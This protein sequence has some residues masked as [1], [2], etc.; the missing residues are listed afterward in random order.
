MAARIAIFA[1]G[2]RGDVEPF[3][4]LALMLKSRGHEVVL[5]APDDFGGMIGRYGVDF[6]SMGVAM[7]DTL[8]SPD[9][10]GA[11]RGNPFSIARLWRDAGIA[12]V[13]GGIDAMEAVGF[14]ADVLIHHPKVMGVSDLAEA[15]GAMVVCASPV[16][17][18]ETSEFPLISIAKDLGPLNKMSWRPLRSARAFYR[19][20]LT[21]WRDNL[22]LKGAW[23]PRPGTDPVF[24]ADMTL[25]AVSPTVMP[26][27]RD[28]RATTHVTGYWRIPNDTEWIPDRSLSD[29]LAYGP[30]PLYI[31]FGSM[32]VRD[33][34][35]DMISGALVYASMRAVVSAGW[36]RLTVDS[37]HVLNIGS[38]PHDWLFRHV[39]GVVHHGGAGTTAAGLRAGLPTLVCPAGVDQPFWGRRVRRLG[40]GPEPVPLKTATRD[41]LADGIRATLRTP[42]FAEAAEAVGHRIRG[43]DGLTRAADLIEATLAARR[44]PR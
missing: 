19:K 31:G 20:S 38:V 17:I 42:R 8:D 29:F 18:E 15:T 28:W 24:G 13:E 4:A 1:Q 41:T 6:T 9:T 33:E 16:P 22:G 23:K 26:T 27:P 32:P 30:P 34:L 37:P 35:G 2:S 11:L 14:D 43:E 21:A 12:M 7:R 25:V 5:A 3:L 10:E 44:P 40:C 36:G 39:A